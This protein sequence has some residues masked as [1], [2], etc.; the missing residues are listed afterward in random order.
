MVA[1]PNSL[2]FSLKPFVML[3]FTKNGDNV[4]AEKL[5][6]YQGYIP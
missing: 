5:G 1:T 6:G 2:I 4:N 3:N